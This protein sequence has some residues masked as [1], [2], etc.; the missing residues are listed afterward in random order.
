MQ[1]RQDAGGAPASESLQALC[2]NGAVDSDETCDTAIESGQAGACPTDCPRDEPCRAYQKQGADCRQECFPLDVTRAVNGDG[3]CPKG[4][5]ADRDS[6][7]GTCGDKIVGPGETCDPPEQC[8][9][10][11][12]CVSSDP[13]LMAV[14]AG[15]PDNCTASC[16][17]IEIRLCRD[18]DL[19]CPA[20]CS[21]TSD[22]DCSG[23]CGNGIVE[24]GEPCDGEVYCSARCTQIFNPS[25]VHRYRFDGTGTSVADSAG[26]PAGS[27]QGANLSGS[28]AVVLSGGTSGPYVDLPNGTL[29]AL[30]NASVEVWFTWDGGIAFQRIFD[31]GNNTNGEGQRGGVATTT[32]FLTPVTT[33]GRA[34]MVI[35]FTTAPDDYANDF[36]VEHPT[37]LSTNVRHQVVGVFDDDDNTLLLYVDGALSA[38]TSGVTGHLADIDDRNAWIGRSNYNDA[39]LDATVHEVRIY[40]SALSAAQV[41]S[42]YN[43][44]PDP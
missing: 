28:G 14:F 15:S 6:D 24:P 26:G 5:R 30:T 29:S 22:D 2:G 42:S 16:S 10:K 18:G 37:A 35:N 4:M 43:A 11:S 38:S 19:C 9:S 34:Q 1:R 27:V 3:C 23:S 13:C 32:W 33:L 25:L 40:S 39:D 20:G 7:C 21:S 41:R 36:S 44:G 31:F 12:A 8:A 17:L